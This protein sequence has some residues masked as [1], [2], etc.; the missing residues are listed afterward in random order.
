MF[1][2]LLAN[3]QTTGAK[4]KKNVTK[5]CIIWKKQNEIRRSLN[6]LMRKM[7]VPFLAESVFVLA[8]SKASVEQKMCP[9]QMNR[10]KTIDLADV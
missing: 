4:K 5:V 2:L 8:L 9:G 7:L 1:Y 3:L 10:R 6:D